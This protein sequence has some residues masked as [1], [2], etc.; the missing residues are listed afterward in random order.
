MYTPT[1]LPRTCITF[2]VTPIDV[3]IY[4]PRL[5]YTEIVTTRV[6]R[7][8]ENTLPEIVLFFLCMN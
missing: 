5:T 3:N 4:T 6:S 1:H 8:S 7:L 2:P